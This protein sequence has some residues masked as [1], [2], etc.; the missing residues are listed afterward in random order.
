LDAWTMMRHKPYGLIISDF[1]MK[2]MNGLMFLHAVRED[3]H[4]RQTR[5]MLITGS[6]DLAIAAEP[7]RSALM[8]SS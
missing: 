8:P 2:P 7:K 1:R 6:A 3:E 4:L 5:F